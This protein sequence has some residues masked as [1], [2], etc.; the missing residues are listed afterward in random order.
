[1]RHL[2]GRDVLDPADH[3]ARQLSAHVQ[4]Q[5]TARSGGNSSVAGFEVMRWDD[6]GMLRF[7]S[8]Q[9]TIPGIAASNDGTGLRLGLEGG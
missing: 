8:M 3:A 9:P 2:P 1:M 4:L 7:R 5:T 6:R